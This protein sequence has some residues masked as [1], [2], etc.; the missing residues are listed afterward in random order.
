MPTLNMC[1]IFY[2]TMALSLW[3]EYLVQVIF[4][5]LGLSPKMSKE[6]LEFVRGY[7]CITA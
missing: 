4:D 1:H 5:K 6:T 2:D 7:G 3:N